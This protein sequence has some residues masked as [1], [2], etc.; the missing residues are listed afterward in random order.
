M[1]S[2]AH[3]EPRGLTVD[4]LEHLR[5][6]HFEDDYLLVDVRA[7][8]T[9]RAGHVPGALSVPFDTLTSQSLALKAA[10]K[11]HVI[12]YA[13]DG[14]CAKQAADWA[15]C[16][17]ELAHTAYLVD[18]IASTG[19]LLVSGVP[20]LTAFENVADIASQLRR[21]FELEKVTYR[22]YCSFVASSPLHPAAGALAVLVDTEKEH[23]QSI[24]KL[25]RI[26]S[27][28]PVRDFE[29]LFEQAP[30]VDIVEGGISIENILRRKA[31]LNEQDAIAFLALGTE[32]E[33]SA[34]DL[35]KNLAQGAAN[36]DAKETFLE[37]AQQEKGHVVLV[38]KAL[39]RVRSEI[40]TAPRLT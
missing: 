34:Y 39:K 24:H 19:A 30:N 5:N 7:S 32:I 21:A 31:E 22:L 25:L 20:R 28:H 23:A 26:L 9:Y 29:D 12:F 2:S 33:L 11:R 27:P 1:K 15:A 35:Y 13:D 4:A 8:N 14:H 18:G 6:T 40:V 38:S 36:V 10:A 16:D 17:L 37:L 3:G